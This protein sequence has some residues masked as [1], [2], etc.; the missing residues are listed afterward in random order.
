LFI[1]PR[2]YSRAAKSIC[3]SRG[4]AVFEL[5]AK[6]PRPGA[7]F[8]QRVQNWASMDRDENMKTTIAVSASLFV[9]FMSAQTHASEA[10]T[11]ADL[12]EICTGSTAENKA[13][14]RFY[15]LGIAQ[16]IEAGMAIADGK[17]KGGRP[18]VPDNVPGSALELAVKMHLGRLSATESYG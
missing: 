7:Q 4:E 6:V 12:Q 18:C 16:G 2:G 3:L 17:T 1:S 13:A 10:M 14:C 8:A 15:V 5:G 11:G 9:A